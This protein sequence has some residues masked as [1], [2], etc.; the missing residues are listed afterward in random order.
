[1]NNPSNRSHTF[2]GVKGFVGIKK[3]INTIDSLFLDILANP[4][5]NGKIKKKNFPEKM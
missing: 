2:W 3:Y 4:V 1:M 5:S